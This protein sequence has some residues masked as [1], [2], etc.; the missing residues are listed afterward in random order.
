MQAV[1]ALVSAGWCVS[2]SERL[3]KKYKWMFAKFFE[4]IPW[5]QTLGQ[6]TTDSILGMKWMQIQDFIFI[7]FNNASSLHFSSGIN[8]YEK[9]WGRGSCIAAEKATLLTSALLVCLRGGLHS[10]GCYWFPVFKVIKWHNY[11]SNYVINFIFSSFQEWANAMAR[12]LSV[13][14]LLCKSL[15]LAGK[16]P[17]CYQTCTRWTPGLR[18]SR[19]CSRSRS[20]SRSKVT[21]YVHFLGFLEWAT[22]SLTVWCN[23]VLCVI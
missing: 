18:A 22:P 3:C 14:K 16:W 12:R 9:L 6:E 1:Y 7:F 2:Q 11:N 4:R 5:C 8:H 20:R 13:C 19:M 15:L 10:L 21:W 23:Y 17:D